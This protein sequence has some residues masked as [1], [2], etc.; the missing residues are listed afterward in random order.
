MHVCWVC[1]VVVMCIRT[2]LLLCWF[3]FC[4]LIQQIASKLV[5]RCFLLL[6][7]RVTMVGFAC[8]TLSKERLIRLSVFLC[9][10]Q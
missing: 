3:Y 4:Y 10:R 1:G 2:R 7:F 9:N 8:I 6:P 5:V